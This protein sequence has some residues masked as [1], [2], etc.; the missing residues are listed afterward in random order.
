MSYRA[1]NI[2]TLVCTTTLVLGLYYMTSSWHSLWALL[3]LLNI[4]YLKGTP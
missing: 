4:N 1:E 3:L 2:A